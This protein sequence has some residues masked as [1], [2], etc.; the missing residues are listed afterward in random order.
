MTHDCSAQKTPDSVYP[1]DARGVAKRFRHAA[2][3]GALDALRDGETMRFRNDHDPLPLLAQI[4]RRFGE[5]M[6]TKYVSRDAGEIVIDFTLA[7][8]SI[9][10]PPPGELRQDPVGGLGDS[11][12]CTAIRPRG[13]DA[14]K[15]TAND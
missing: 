14:V 10:M 15:V 11:C 12:Q 4:R 7:G 6:R 5:R 3:F 1:F 9:A 8:V 13:Q 2:I